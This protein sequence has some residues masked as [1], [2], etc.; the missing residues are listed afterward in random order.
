MQSKNLKSQVNESIKKLTSVLKEH[1]KGRIIKILF[2]I[3]VPVFIVVALLFSF[4]ISNLLYEVKRMKIKSENSTVL[5]LAEQAYKNGYLENSAVYYQSYVD[6]NVSGVEKIIAYKRLF[7]ISVLQNKLDESLGYLDKL[8]EIDKNLLEIYI[9]RIK[10]Y[11]RLN[12]LEKAREEIDRDY[13]RFRNSPEFRDL[14]GIY[15][16][17]TGDYGRALKEFE[18][19]PFGRREFDVNKKIIQCMIN[20]AEYDK[21]LDYIKRIGKKYS[22]EF[23][24]E[25]EAE[26]I[27]LKQTARILKG[28]YAGSIAELQRAESLTT[29]YKDITAKLILYS[30]MSQ[31]LSDDVY[32]TIESNESSFSND[33]NLLRVIGDYYYFKENYS[34]AL[35]YYEALKGLRKLSESEVMTLADIYYFTGDYQKSIDSMKELLTKFDFKSPALYKNLGMAYAGLSDFQNEVFFLKEGL[36]EFPGD[37]DFYVRLAKIFIDKRDYDEALSYINEG[38]AAYKRNNDIFYDKRL[39]ALYAYVMEAGNKKMQEDELLALREK[40]SLN[41]DYYFKLIRY[42]IGKNKYPDAERELETAARL[43]QDEYQKRIFNV[44]DVI[45]SLHLDNRKE[46]EKASGELLNRQPVDVDD[47]INQAV[48][49]IY[50]EDYDKALELLTTLSNNALEENLKTRIVYL[51]ALCYFY[52]RNYPLSQKLIDM[53][54]DNEKSGRRVSYLESLIKANYFKSGNE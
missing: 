21:C 18:S 3:F 35:S 28:D 53:L 26:I 49:F 54:P 6:S 10:I 32:N 36:D 33:P 12:E 29:K 27:I 2:F 51:Q 25:Y 23:D 9:N 7:E 11:I 31:D 15:Y 43:S 4:N 16:I 47:S 42:Y 37:L 52:K 13:H 24:P 38:K 46:Y 50:N 5:K 19:I 8:E 1:K 41:P 30:G 45:V 44:L 17:K 39:D 34:R 40:E 48:I 14:T 22:R 20:L